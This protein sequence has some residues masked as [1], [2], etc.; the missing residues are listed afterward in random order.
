MGLVFKFIFWFVI[1][2]FVF[3]AYILVYFVVLCYLIVLGF[4]RLQ[5]A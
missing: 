4:M 3:G 2:C 1:W 5:F